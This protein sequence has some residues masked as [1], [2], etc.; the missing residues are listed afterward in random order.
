L[1]IVFIDL[2]GT[3]ENAFLEGPERARWEYKNS[4]I[5]VVPISF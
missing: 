3:Q 1:A 5:E 4:D 2:G